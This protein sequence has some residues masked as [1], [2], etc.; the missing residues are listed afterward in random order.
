[1]WYPPLDGSVCVDDVR[2]NVGEDTPVKILS[3]K[4][5]NSEFVAI[6]YTNQ[7]G[8][9]EV[10]LVPGTYLLCAGEGIFSSCIEKTITLGEFRE[11][12]LGIDI[13]KP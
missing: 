12:N 6:V 13:A 11:I 8:F 2:T 1:L 10:N 5:G 4:E 9:Y 7:E 3:Y